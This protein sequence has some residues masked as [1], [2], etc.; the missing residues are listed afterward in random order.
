MGAISGQKPN[1]KTVF[2]QALKPFLKKERREKI[3]QAAKILTITRALKAF[4]NND[5]GGV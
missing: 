3:E 4:K 5:T 2:L 1:E